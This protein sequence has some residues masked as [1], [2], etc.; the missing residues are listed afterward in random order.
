LIAEFDLSKPETLLQ[1]RQLQADL[2][3]NPAAYT[4]LTARG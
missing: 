3:I 4:A 1:A 2:I